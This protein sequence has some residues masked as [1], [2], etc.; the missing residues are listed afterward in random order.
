[1]QPQ[2]K[3]SCEQTILH[4][5]R[6]ARLAARCKPA[7]KRPASLRKQKG[8]ASPACAGARTRPPRRPLRTD[9]HRT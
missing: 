2:A 8:G 6:R 4:I 5:S 1:M 3:F 7:P 9:R